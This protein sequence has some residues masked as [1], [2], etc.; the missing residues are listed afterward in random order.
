MS[1]S[2]LGSTSKL[3]FIEAYHPFDLVIVRGVFHISLVGLGLYGR[4]HGNCLIDVDFGIEVNIF[5]TIEV[6]T[7]PS[8]VFQ[9]LLE[10]VVDPAQTSFIVFVELIQLSILLVRLGIFD[11]QFILPFLGG[12]KDWIVR[13]DKLNYLLP[14]V[15]CYSLDLV[16]R[17]LHL[18][19]LFDHHRELRE[20]RGRQFD[21]MNLLIGFLNDHHFIATVLLCLFIIVRLELERQASKHS[22]F[23]P[24]ES[25]VD[26]LG[27]GK[28]D[29][30]DGV[31]EEH[32][33]RPYIF[34]EEL[35]DVFWRV[36]L[37]GSF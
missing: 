36:K 17:V 11:D 28:A 1:I 10:I 19:L 37:E 13:V 5:F 22:F 8:E 27:V 6:S 29:D 21:I 23:I 33:E 24:T 35:I 26:M 14:A 4:V 32:V 7:S 2:S 34:P 30:G 15:L 3:S 18:Q 9:I 16:Q 20:L 31:L 12:L 25:K